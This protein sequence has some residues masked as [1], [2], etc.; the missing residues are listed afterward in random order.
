MSACASYVDR[1]LKVRYLDEKGVDCS[2]K[3][4]V[5]LALDAIRR[6]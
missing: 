6:L 1:M 3:D 5:G 4:R 2:A